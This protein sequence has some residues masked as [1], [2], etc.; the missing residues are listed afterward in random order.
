MSISSACFSSR[1]RLVVVGRCAVSLPYRQLRLS[2]SRGRKG[3]ALALPVAAFGSRLPLHRRGVL[4][5]SSFPCRVALGPVPGRPGEL[6][7]VMGRRVPLGVSRSV[8]TPC[9]VSRLARPATCRGGS[10]S[11]GAASSSRGAPCLSVS[12]SRRAA[13]LPLAAS[14]FVGTV[15]PTHRSRGRCAM[16][17]R[18]APEL[19]RYA[20]PYSVHAND[21][22]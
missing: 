12:A 3:H 18:S 20:S 1:S 2:V 19:R 17:P 9:R 21:L 16:K 22:T 14:R 7:P 6:V 5:S 4:S 8:A 11:S 10:L 13:G 15:A